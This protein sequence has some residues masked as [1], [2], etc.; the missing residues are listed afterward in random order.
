LYPFIQLTDSISLPS[1]FLMITLVYCLSIIYVLKRAARLKMDRNLAL[2][3]SLAIMI[4]GF[5]CARLFHILYEKPHYYLKAPLEVLKFWN[6][7]FVFYAGAIGAVL[8]GLVLLKIRKEKFRPWLD[9][10]APIGA[11]GY[12]LGRFA[13][14][15][16]GCCYGNHCDLPWNLD[17]RHPTPLYAS[18]WEFFILAVLVIF[19]RRKSNL[20]FK[21]LRQPGELF[22]LWIGLHAIGHILMETFRADD[23]GA[24]PLG[25]SISTWI[26]IGLITFSVAG[27]VKVSKKL[28]AKNSHLG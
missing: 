5:I 11:F 15:L 7:G 19:E 23:R 16:N 6:G 27:T 10:Y 24:E 22:F 9:F 21:G 1:Y 18:L 13:C 20:F 8:S 28:K 17:G 4:G 3:I 26:S 25:M 14:L 12:G 2:D